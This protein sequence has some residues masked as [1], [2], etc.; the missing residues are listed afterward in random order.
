LAFGFCI[1]NF[2]HLAVDFGFLAFGAFWL[3]AFGFRM[4]WH[5]V[6]DFWHLAF[7]FCL[8][9]F[10]ALYFSTWHVVYDF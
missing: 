4:Y 1:F 6:F 5:L 7:G 10:L 2:W 8:S 9:G 3:L